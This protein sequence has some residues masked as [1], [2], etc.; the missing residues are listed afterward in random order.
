[1]VVFHKKSGPV[2]IFYHFAPFQSFVL[3]HLRAPKKVVTN[4]GDCYNQQGEIKEALSCGDCNNVEKEFSIMTV[5]E[6]L[7]DYENE[8]NPSG[9]RFK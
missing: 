6:F 9:I 7:K 2:Y 1:M 3:H 8:I 4:S 5:Y